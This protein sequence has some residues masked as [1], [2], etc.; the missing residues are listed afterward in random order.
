MNSIA[1]GP[2]DESA[3]QY[4]VNPSFGQHAKNTIPLLHQPGCYCGKNRPGQWKSLRPGRLSPFEPTD[5]RAVEGCRYG[6]GARKRV[7]VGQKLKLCLVFQCLLLQ[8]FLGLIFDEVMNLFFR[9]DT[10]LSLS[11]QLQSAL[12]ELVV[13]LYQRVVHVIGRQ[14]TDFLP[15]PVPQASCSQIFPFR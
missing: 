13:E 2:A 6:W 3:R 15:S 5:L 14:K 4:G 8:L 12:T 10:G 1:T 7:I 11:V 9:Q